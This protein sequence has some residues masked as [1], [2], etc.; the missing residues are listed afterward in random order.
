MRF[1]GEKKKK[2]RGVRKTV[3][4]ISMGDWEAEQDARALARAESVK[5]DPERL[6]RAQAWAAKQLDESK[7]KKV[8]AEKLI[9]LGNEAK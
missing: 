3:E 9:E 4:A 1:P 6:K 2:K 7:A 5:G 8:E